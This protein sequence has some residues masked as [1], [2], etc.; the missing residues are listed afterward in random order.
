M[1]ESGE[2]K[3]WWVTLPGILTQLVALVTA[4]TGLIAV[5]YQSGFLHRQESTTTPPATP[6]VTAAAMPVP[7]LPVALQPAAIAPSPPSEPA[8]ALPAAPGAIPIKIGD[9]IADGIPQAGAGNI[10]SPGS[11]DRYQF[12]AT[13]GQRVYFRT[14]EY[15]KGMDQINWRLTDETG[16]EVFRACLGCGEPGVQTL[17]HG[18]TY[19]LT[20]G[21]EKE[22]ATGSYKVRLTNVP[23]DGKFS[24]GLPATIRD[25]VPGAGAGVIEASGASDVYSFTAAVK[26][27]VFFRVME[28]GK[29]MDQINWWLTD[30]TGQEVFRSCLGCGT[31]GVQILSHGG[32]YIL[33]VGNNREHATGNYKLGLTIP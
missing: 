30:E 4:L 20:V 28:Y 1:A 8:P 33:T 25:G 17:L 10:E 2:H 24:I 9:T 12:N 3:N 31:P 21:N 16:Q 13:A 7:P 6:V 11:E 18:G 22:P 32:T 29:D 15:G 27:R 19:T 26:Q 14:V 5:L 23:A